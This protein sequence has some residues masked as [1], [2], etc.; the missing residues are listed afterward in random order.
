MRL[1]SSDRPRIRHDEESAGHKI[2]RSQNQSV[3]KSVG[4]KISRSQNQI[5]HKISRSQNQSVTKSV[6]HKISRSQGEV[7][8][9]ERIEFRILPETRPE[10]V[11]VRESA[12]QRTGIPAN[13]HT[14]ERSAGSVQ[15][16]RR[17]QIKKDGP[18][19][20][21]SRRHALR[22]PGGDLKRQALTA[23][24]VSPSCFNGPFEYRD[25]CQ[26]ATSSQILGVITF[27]LP[28]AAALRIAEKISCRW[29]SASGTRRQS[30]LRVR[31]SQR[32][33]SAGTQE[34]SDF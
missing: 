21:R 29:L 15:R 30:S 5:G 23:I 3:T 22:G 27:G 7:K 13:G 11:H 34:E 10:Y 31:W 19:F 32:G 20:R 33:I 24:H 17:G 9:A 16:P 8:Q 28:W 18:Q 1:G 25:E 2:S 6:G 14:S 26:S 4:H 12:A